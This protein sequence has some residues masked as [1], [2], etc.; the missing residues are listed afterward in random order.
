MHTMKDC[1]VYKTISIIGKKWT[2]RILLE[3]YK[4]ADTY[5]RF[6][7]LRDALGTITPKVLVQRLR[8]LEEDG[9]IIRKVDTSHIPISSEYALSDSGIALMSVIQEIK[10]WGL[11][12]KFENEECRC[13][14]CKTCT[15]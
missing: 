13:T 2:L 10:Q 15:L 6:N 7:A 4:G 9:I 11:S 12:Y 1:T 14:R 5:K 3:L 8:E